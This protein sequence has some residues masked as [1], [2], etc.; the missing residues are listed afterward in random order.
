MSFTHIAFSVAELILKLD[1][2]YVGK[3]LTVPVIHEKFL[4]TKPPEGGLVLYPRESPLHSGE[5]WVPIF[6][7]PRTWQLW[8]DEL[9]R[10]VF[11]TSPDS[12]PER[13]IIVDKNFT[14]GEIISEETPEY[15]LKDIDIIFF[16]NWLASF[17]DVIIHASAIE[18]DGRAFVF[19]GESGAGKSTMV[20]NLREM[21]G[22][23]I[24]GED[25]IALRFIKDR[26]WIFGTPWHLAPENCAPIGLPL[27]EL[28]FLDRFLQP[29]M[30]QIKP[31]EGIARLMQTAFIPYYR[32]ECLDGILDRLELLGQCVPFYSLSYELGEDV[33]QF[34]N[35]I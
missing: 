1:A 33:W 13:Q 22:G 23:T 5:N 17:C 10:F 28:V 20:K 19:V 32:R 24:L 21:T 12:P 2:Q 8:E 11:V 27:K 7:Q 16:I 14:M 30:V 25:N 3:T 4:R 29:C 15:P 6:Q 34:L 9:D 35:H 31:I 18:I 26:F